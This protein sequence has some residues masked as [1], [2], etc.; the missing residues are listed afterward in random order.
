M[1]FGV[2]ML[3]LL[4]PSHGNGVKHIQIQQCNVRIYVVETK[5]KERE[6]ERERWWKKNRFSIRFEITIQPITMMV[7]RS[8][9][10]NVGIVLEEKALSWRLER[11]GGQRK[12][13]VRHC[14][15]P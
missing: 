7:T 13:D 11:G 12:K 4:L 15:E 5:K 3:L 9:L 10:H 8:E 14:I 6:I 2:R 1:V